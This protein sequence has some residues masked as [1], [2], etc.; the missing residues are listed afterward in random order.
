MEREAAEADKGAVYEPD[1]IDRG[2]SRG[3]NR[4]RDRHH[5]RDRHSSGKSSSKHRLVLIFLMHISKFS[6]IAKFS[7]YII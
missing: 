5:D 1:S 4:D 2:K 6:F 7:V 3:K